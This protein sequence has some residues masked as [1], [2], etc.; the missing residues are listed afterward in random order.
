MTFDN[1]ADFEIAQTIKALEAQQIQGE[2]EGTDRNDILA[3][4][5]KNPEHG[6]CVRGVGSGVTNK[7]YF[8]YNKPLPQSQLQSDL[9]CL[10]SKL[11]NVVNTQ[12]LLLSYLLS[13]GQVN[14]EQLK[15][16]GDSNGN[17]VAHQLVGIQAGGSGGQAS[18]QKGGSGGE[19]LDDHLDVFGS[20]GDQGVRGFNFQEKNV[21][22]FEVQPEPYHLAWPEEEYVLENENLETHVLNNEQDITGQPFPKADKQV[23]KEIAAPSP[24]SPSSQSSCTRKYIITHADKLKLT[25]NLVRVFKDVA[26]AMKTSGKTKSFTVLAKVF[27]NEKCVTLDYEDMLD[28]GHW[29]LAA[30]CPW[31]GLVHWLDPAGVKDEPPKFAQTIINKAM[32]NFSAEHRKDITKMKKKPYIKWISIEFPRQA[33]GSSGSGYYVCRYM[34]E[35]IES[36]QMIIPDK[37]AEMVLGSLGWDVEQQVLA[38]VYFKQVPP[39]YS[40]QMID[41]LRE[42]WISYV[43]GYHQPNDNNDDLCEL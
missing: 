4:V 9:K 13:S 12:N 1:P 28:C 27:Q 21:Q 6:G 37:V 34:I 31:V 11:E 7:M 41:E 15:E 10:K 40:Q 39:T 17:Q 24:H 2:I 8:G 22:A 36:R 16:L 14:A 42:R 38:E 30:I 29:M 5:L 26:I 18:V 32:I 25:S 43:T 20:Q 19:E 33:N 23:P 35:T 3:L